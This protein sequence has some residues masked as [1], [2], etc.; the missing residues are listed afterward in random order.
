V[1]YV[2]GIARFVNKKKNEG[3]EERSIRTSK[4]ERYQNIRTTANV[5][6]D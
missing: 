3:I 6:D 4:G 1:M 2:P 5:K